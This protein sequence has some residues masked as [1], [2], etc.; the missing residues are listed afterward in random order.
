MQCCRDSR[1]SNAKE[2]PLKFCYDGYLDFFS[3]DSSLVRQTALATEMG[4]GTVQYWRLM[5]F[6]QSSVNYAFKTFIPV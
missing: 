3:P 1:L 2:G 5:G 4:V 6:L